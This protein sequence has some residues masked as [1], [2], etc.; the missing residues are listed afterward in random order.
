MVKIIL[1]CTLDGGISFNNKIPWYIKEDLNLFKIITNNSNIIM[2]YN[3]WLSL[4]KKPLI[5]RNNIVLTKN[6]KK[7]MEI[8]YPNIK[9]YDN[10]D[11]TLKK[12]NNNNS[13]YIGGSQIYNYLINNNLV[14][15][16]HIS[17]INNKY[18]CDNFIEINKLREKKHTIISKQSFNDFTYMHISF[19]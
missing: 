2:G 16:A 7:N 13:Y 11:D 6:N 12:Y 17:F 4:P 9:T 8:N 3:T 1:A 10:I 5:N 14:T 15:E 19:H 18:E